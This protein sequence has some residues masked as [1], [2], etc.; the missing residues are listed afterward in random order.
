MTSLRFF[1]SPPILFGNHNALHYMESIFDLEYDLVE[2]ESYITFTN[3]Y[4]LIRPL[5][6]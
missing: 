4:A 1:Y 3:I 6:S 5:N 2:L